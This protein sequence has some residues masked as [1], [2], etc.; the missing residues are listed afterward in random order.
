MLNRFLKSNGGSLVSQFHRLR[1]NTTVQIYVQEFEEIGAL[2]REENKA[3]TE[4]YF[5]ESFI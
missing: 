3:L 2:M 1:Q 5:V 4:Q